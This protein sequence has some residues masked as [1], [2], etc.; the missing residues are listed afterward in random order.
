[1]VDGS[2]SDVRKAL[3]RMAQ[4]SKR[5]PNKG[6]RRA[7]VSNW[8]WD[9]EGARDYPR[10]VYKLGHGRNV[11]KPPP[12]QRKDVVR[13]WAQKAR[14]HQTHNFVFNLGL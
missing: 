9:A 1:M 12:R 14:K 6:L 13:Q 11:P 2:D 4:P 10:P 7:H 5:G 8:V 3:T